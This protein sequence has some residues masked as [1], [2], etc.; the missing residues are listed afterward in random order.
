MITYYREAFVSQNSYF[1]VDRIIVTVNFTSI[2]DLQLSRTKPQPGIIKEFTKFS[3]CQK[4][5]ED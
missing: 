3:L 2:W 1:D 5:G 4:W